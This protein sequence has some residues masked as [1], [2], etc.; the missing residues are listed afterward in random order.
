MEAKAILRNC[1]LSPRKMRMVADQVR[2]VKVD[3][4]L[5]ILQWNQKP[6]Y[7]IYLNKLIRSAVANW[8]QANSGERIEDNDLYVKTIMVDGG[9]TLK[10]LRTAP[11]GRGYRQVKRTNHVTVVVDSLK[12]KESNQTESDNA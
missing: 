5:N 8:S 11:Q 10:R 2:G 4:A 7:A 6:S 3:R 12:S 9:F 1:P